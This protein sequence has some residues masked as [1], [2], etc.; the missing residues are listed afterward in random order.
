LIDP[1]GR[2]QTERHQCPCRGGSPALGVLYQTGVPAI[3]VNAAAIDQI[4][5]GFRSDRPPASGTE[6]R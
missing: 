3:E 1:Y 5:H 6:I 2:P 4:E